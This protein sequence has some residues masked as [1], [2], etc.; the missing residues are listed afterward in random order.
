[1][2]LHVDPVTHQLV[3]ARPFAINEPAMALD[4]MVAQN[5]DWEDMTLSPPR[6]DAEGATRTNL[7]LAATGDADKYRVL[8]EVGIDITCDTRRLIELEEP[9]PN[10]PSVTTWSPWKIYDVENFVGSNGM[11]SCN[12]ESVVSGTDA[13]GSP[14]AYLIT[15]SGRK[16]LSRSLD[17]TTGRDPA[18]PRVMAGSGAPYAPAATYVGAVKNAKGLQFTAADSNGTNVALL[19]KKTAT[20]P[21]QILTWPILPSGSLAA[22]LITTEPTKTP[23]SC[24]GAEGLSYNRQPTDATAFTSN[25]TL[26]QDSRNSTFRYWLLPDS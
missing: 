14:Q 9:D 8:D 3:E 25:L 26:I 1:L 17:P 16:I 12:V 13:A 4:P 2:A 23:V 18:T 22:T 6:T 21:C 19:V 11:R 10:D 15:R 20:V 5:N 24:L 7:I